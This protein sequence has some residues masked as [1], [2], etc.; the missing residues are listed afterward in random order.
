MSAGTQ[1]SMNPRLL[2]GNNYI[3]D[4]GGQFQQRLVGGGNVRTITTANAACSANFANQFGQQAIRVN[5][6]PNKPYRFLPYQENTC[7]VL[8]LDA[9]AQLLLTGPL[10]GC[11]V[12]VGGPV[13]TPSVCHV[14][15]NDLGM[16]A[17]NAAAKRTMALGALGAAGFTFRLEADHY[18]GYIGF[19]VGCKPRRGISLKLVSWTGSRGADTWTFYFYGYN[20]DGRVLK[21]LTANDPVNVHA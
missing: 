19:V 17:T 12:Y 9:A 10:T 4:G 1:L 3:L 5:P 18:T 13:A 14:N 11:H 16:G 6:N 7:T 8:Q 15:R 20:A 2:L 21:R